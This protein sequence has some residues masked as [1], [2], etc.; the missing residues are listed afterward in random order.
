[1][2]ME[3]LTI[4][5]NRDG[6]RLRAAERLLLLFSRRVLAPPLSAATHL[7]TL[8]N[9]LDYSKRMIPDFPERIR[10]KSVL[11]YGC[12]PG[13]QAVAM[14]QAGARSVHGLDINNEWLDQARTLASRAT[15]VTFG[16]EPASEQYD[17]VISLGSMEHFREPG[18]EL[19]RMCS[20]AR[21]E[22]IVSFA[23]PWYSPYGTHLNG[24]TKVPWL[25]LMFSERTLMNFRNLYPDGSDG[26]KR[27]EDIRGGLNRMTVKR[28]E[29][30]I[31]SVS[32]MKV[33]Y[34][35]LRGVKGLDLVTKV[36]ALRE[37]MT[38][39]LTCILRTE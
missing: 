1:M 10:G 31:G 14:R 27:F 32:G 17:V 38:T 13:W 2:N 36:P 26:A 21:E 6:E 16:K 7:Y 37:L 4:K 3:A 12:G 29:R 18:K 39:A 33:E 28:F 22:V 30:L 25:N 11:D 23:E 8:E 24:T 15:N 35:Q 20:L 19:A 34:L 5:R 9:A